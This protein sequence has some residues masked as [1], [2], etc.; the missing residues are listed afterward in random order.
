[1]YVLRKVKPIVVALAVTAC[2]TSHVQAHF[3]WVQ[4][5]G[6]QTGGQTVKVAFSESG[7]AGAAHLVDRIA[8]AKAVVFGD[9]KTEC[10]LQPSLSDETGYLAAAVPAGVNRAHVV[11]KYG[12]FSHGE[13]TSLLYYYAAY[14]RCALSDGAV[15]SE[16][17]DQQ[18]KDKEKLKFCVAA[19]LIDSAVQLT[20]LWQG[21]PVGEAEVAV[22]APD[23]TSTVTV[24]NV[25]GQVVVQD[26]QQGRYRVRARHVIE[27][28]GTED[29]VPYENELHY[30]TLTLDVS[31]AP[32]S[33]IGKAEQP[34]NLSAA[35]LLE[36]ARAARAIWKEFPGFVADVKIHEGGQSQS[37][38]IQ[39]DASGAVT[40]EGIEFP[41]HSRAQGTLRSLVSHRMGN[42]SANDGISF[43]D[44]D[45]DHPSGRLLNLDYDTAMGS[46]Y[47]VKDDV[48]REVNRN[49]SDGH[50]TITVLDVYR[51]PEGKYLPAN[52]VINTWNP[53][54]S[55]KSS[56]A[57][58]ESWVRVGQFDLPVSH[59]SVT[60]SK[61]EHAELSIELR[62]HRL[63]D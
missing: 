40:F 17:G 29:G 31:N 28:S 53:D 10:D 57:V 4:L 24:S 60:S 43:A 63:I 41:E 48:I 33:L 45:L 59:F 37:G 36:R 5:D 62:E 12:T 61:A 39:V 52:Y 51:N 32:E 47:R 2:C 58:Q 22:T 44:T 8:H 38:K 27:Q 13:A 54:E 21:Q 56:T 19:E 42:G 34:E 49:S 55:L 26:V 23:G 14:Q 11:C 6:V 25:H 3:V 30:S 1:M 15:S 50:F 7:E 18:Q 16:N 46:S 20:V 9:A 35:A